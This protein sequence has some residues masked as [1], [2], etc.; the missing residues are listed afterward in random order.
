[1]EMPKQLFIAMYMMVWVLSNGRVDHISAIPLARDGMPSALAV[2]TCGVGAV[3]VTNWLMSLFAACYL[4]A[5]V[6]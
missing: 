2:G 1:M 6:P 5:S 3:A 4:A